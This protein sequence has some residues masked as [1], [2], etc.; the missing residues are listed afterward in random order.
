MKKI[1]EEKSFTVRA[2]NNGGSIQYYT[3]ENMPSWLDVTPSSGTINPVSGTDIKFDIDP[4]LNIGTYDEVVY[5][6]NDNN[7]VEA[8]PITVKV[9][10]EKPSWSVNPSDYEYNMSI[11][12]KIL[13]NNLYSA[14]E[15]DILAA[16]NGSECVGICNNKYYKIN[17]TYYAMLTVYSNQAEE[18]KDLEFRIWDASTGSTY[19]AEPESPIHFV[20]NNVIGSPSI[21][22]VFTP[23]DIAICLCH[24]KRTIYII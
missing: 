20:N 12:G 1:N 11:F 4:S 18:S 3:V 19:I 9:E 5:L 10:G 2:N 23:R 13:I 14:D 21:P 8:L 16:F 7:V 22:T 17:D 24:W 6:R 15:E